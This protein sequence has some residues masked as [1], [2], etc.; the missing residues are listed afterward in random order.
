MTPGTL[1]V[2][3]VL[4][5]RSPSRRQYSLAIIGGLGLIAIYFQAVMYFLQLSGA[6]CVW[7]EKREGQRKYQKRNQA[8]KLS[9]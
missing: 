7:L 3:V 9:V 5:P 8:R 1:R 2:F 6:S 4:L